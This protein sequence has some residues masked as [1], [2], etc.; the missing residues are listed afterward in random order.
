MLSWS[1]IDITTPIQTIDGPMLPSGV[2]LLFSD[3][4]SDLLALSASGSASLDILP[5]GTYTTQ[6]VAAALNLFG[7]TPF[8]GPVQAFLTFTNP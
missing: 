6:V 5:P 3:G 4:Q 1:G 7:P 8:L 2:D